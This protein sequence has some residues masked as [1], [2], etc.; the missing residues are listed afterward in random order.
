MF[1]D[2]VAPHWLPGNTQFWYMVGTGPDTHEYVRVD[3]ERGERTPAFDHEQLARALQQAGVAD[4][5]PEKLGLR[6]LAWPDQDTLCFS[7]DH[8]RWCIRTSD[9]AIIHKTALEIP[10]LPAYAP[11]DGPPWSWRTEERTLVDFVNRTDG[12]VELLWLNF[13]AQRRSYGKLAA[14]QS[15]TL[16]TF[17]A[18]VWLVVDASGNPLAVYSATKSPAVA[19]ITGR[20]AA[21]GRALARPLAPDTMPSRSARTG[22]PEPLRFVNRTGGEIEMFWLDFAGNRRSYGKI[23]ADGSHDMRTF[24]G[25]VW[26]ITNSAGQRLTGFE[27]LEVPGEAIITGKIAAAGKPANVSPDGKW[28]VCVEHH[29]VVLRDVASGEGFALSSDGTPDNRYRDNFFWSPDSRKLAGVRAQ[30]GE[31]RHLTLVES[32]PA[33]QVHPKLHTIPYYKPGDRLPHPRPALW[34][35]ATKR[36]LP[37]DEALFPNPFTETENLN[38]RWDRDSSRF[39][40]RYDDRGHQ[41]HRLIAIDGTTGEAT[42]I[43]DERS[44]TFIWHSTATALVR[45]LEDSNELIW[46][47]ERDGWNHLYLYNL[48]S[49]RVINQIT[50][51]EWLVR[52]VDNVDVKSRQ[53]WFRAG[54]IVP[55]QDPYYLHYCRVNFDG[56]GLVVLSAGDGTHQCTFSPDRRFLI[57]SYSRV[58]LPPITNLRRCADGA[59]VCELERADATELLKS[60]WRPAEPFVAKGR[61]D[62]TDIYGIIVRPAGFDPARKY[63]VIEH[64][65]ANP[66]GA[67]V[68]K[69]YGPIGPMTALANLGFIVVQIDGMGT[70]QRSKKF[71]DV[72]WKN[73]GD[74]GL[75]DRIRWIKAAAEKYPQMDISRVGIYGVSAGGQSALRALLVHGDFYQVAAADCGCH[76]NRVDK[77]SWN[78]QWM[79]WPIGPHYAEQSNVTHAAALQGKLLLM[80]G[81]LDRNV[82]PACTL[83][84]ADALIKANKNF[85]LLVVP[86]AGHGVSRLPYGN[87]RLQEFFVRHLLN[88]GPTRNVP[89][90][91]RAY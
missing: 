69:A 25:H 38:L 20:V 17:L 49:G 31:E 45:Y 89:K 28:S 11:E 85:E 24:G 43:V 53:I 65:Y 4:A 84:V 37:I 88:R 74:A 22:T 52:A 82:D 6:D 58:D 73:L 42:A 63:P 80:V 76:D 3:A 21:K 62:A 86:G 81:E 29:N 91:S 75:P 13:D 55:G 32:A 51:G 79:G 14:G 9:G 90:D 60:G 19:E 64:I 70:G 10:R 23:P 12:E 50:Q 27:T 78:E 35:I 54:G 48:K 1:R 26:L 30:P 77:V 59:L 46:M 57:D 47:S 39:L 68:P 71:H 34:D 67:Y 40:F 2:R 44:E 36:Q 83:Q 18:H 87:R 72:C 61:D 15:R 41:V 16:R 7:T 66:Q 5:Q 8:C 33:D 56:S